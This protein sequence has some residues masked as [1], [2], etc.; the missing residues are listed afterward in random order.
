MIAL[1]MD[2]RVM[3]TGRG[4]F[5]LP[6]VDIRMPFHPAMLALLR[7]KL[8][9]AQLRGAVLEGKRYVAEEALTA[10]LVDGAVTEDG[11][12]KAAKA[13]VARL[14]HKERSIFRQMK[15]DLY[16]ETADFMQQEL[17]ALA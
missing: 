6:E 9:P 7:A 11:L 1:A 4:W 5:C 13:M 10:G 16:G 14:Q 17:R 15:N 12:L 2:Y 8:G 3:R